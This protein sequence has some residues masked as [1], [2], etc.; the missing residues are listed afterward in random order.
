MNRKDY[1]FQVSGGQHNSKQLV[2]AVLCVS[3]RKFLKSFLNASI[4]MQ[5][6]SKD[7]VNFS[8]FNSFTVRRMTFITYYR[9]ILIFNVRNEIL[10]FVTS[11]LV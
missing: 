10:I 5:Y 4:N 3:V 2:A 7:N 6:A 1:E 9:L 11:S 8:C